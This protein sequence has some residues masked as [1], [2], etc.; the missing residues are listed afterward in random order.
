MPKL[1]EMAEIE[2][3]PTNVTQP[4]AYGAAALGVA[5]LLLAQRVDC[6]QLVHALLGLLH[7]GFA[8]FLFWWLRSN[9]VGLQWLRDWSKLD[10]MAEIQPHPTNVTR[11]AAYVAAAL[12]VALLLLALRVDCLQL[13]HALLGLLHLG[14]AAFLF[15]WLRSNK[16]GLQW[17]RDLFED[18]GSRAMIERRT[19]AD[20]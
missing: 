7:L 17:L 2:P 10:E 20:G 3:H 15:W 9:K 6:L 12:G 8:A 13:V 19:K 5:L 18:P 16:V 4:A 1:D 14:F 11:P